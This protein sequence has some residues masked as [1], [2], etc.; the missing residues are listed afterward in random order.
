[1]A[2]RDGEQNCALCWVQGETVDR[3]MAHIR[4]RKTEIPTCGEL[5]YVIVGGELEHIFR[6][7]RCQA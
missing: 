7:L 4:R 5:E 6:L 1:M 3:E 2:S